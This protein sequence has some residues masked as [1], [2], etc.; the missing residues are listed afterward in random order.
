[1]VGRCQDVFAAKWVLFLANDSR[2][3][4]KDDQTNIKTSVNMASVNHI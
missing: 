2:Y 1:M 3:E 4:N